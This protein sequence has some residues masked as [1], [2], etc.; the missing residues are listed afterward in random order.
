MGAGGQRAGAWL[1]ALSAALSLGVGVLIPQEGA[2]R[3]QDTHTVYSSANA[4]ETRYEG[5]AVTD[6]SA[7]GA[8]VENTAQDLAETVWDESGPQVQETRIVHTSSE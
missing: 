3:A 4:G 5:E 2:S 1:L 7:D 6:V 8:A